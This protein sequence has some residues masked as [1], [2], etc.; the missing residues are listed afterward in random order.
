MHKLSTVDRLNL[1]WVFINISFQDLLKTLNYEKDVDLST[2]VMEKRKKEISIVSEPQEWG[3]WLGSL[4]LIFLLPLSII[5]PQL[6]CTE[7]RCSFGYPN[8]TTDLNTY[9]NLEA[10]V[11]YLGYLLFVAISSIIPIGRKIDGPQSRMGRLQYRS[12][13]NFVNNELFRLKHETFAIILSLSFSGFLCAVLSLLVFIMCIY[14]DIKITDFIIENCVQLSISGW[15]IGTILSVLL[16]LKSDRAPIANLNIHG[17][18]NST[19]YNFWQG[20][21]INPRIGP[22]D[23]KLCLFRSSLIAM[24][25]I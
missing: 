12:N 8:I 14:K 1:Q 10:F 3:G 17:S 24:V 25:G 20:R 5:L 9:I 6:M 13:G 18:T 16:F 23:F 15:I 4:I 11:A 7:K 21:E 19:I 2:Q 22:I